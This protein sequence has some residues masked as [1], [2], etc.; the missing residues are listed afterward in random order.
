MCCVCVGNVDG[1]GVDYFDTVVYSDFAIRASDSADFK[2]AVTSGYL[3]QR[4]GVGGEIAHRLR[5]I[6]HK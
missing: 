6:P 5:N 3:Y 2:L 4:V 1:S